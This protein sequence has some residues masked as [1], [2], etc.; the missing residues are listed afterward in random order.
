METTQVI[1]RALW[2]MKDMSHEQKK[3]F[4]DH[5][6]KCGMNNFVISMLYAFTKV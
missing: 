1:E 3:E 2:F 4:I 5:L 6:Q